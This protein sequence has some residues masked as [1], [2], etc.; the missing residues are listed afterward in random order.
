MNSMREIGVYSLR[1]QNLDL[2][3]EKGQLAILIQDPKGSD[4]YRHILAVRFE[5]KGEEISFSGVSHEEYSSEKIRQYLYRRGSSNGPDFTPTTRITEPVKTFNGKFLGWFSQDFDDPDLKFDDYDFL[6]LKN[7]KDCVFQNSDEICSQLVEKYAEIDKAENAILTLTI[8][9]GRKNYIGDYPCFRK[10]L[11]NQALNN[12]H[13]KYGKKSIAK[14]QVCSVCGQKSDEVY[15]FVSTYTFYTVDKPGMVAG[16]FDQTQT[17]KNYPV[18]QRCALTLEEG[19][20]YI[21]EYSSF[22]FYDFSYFVIPRPFK[23]ENNADIYEILEQF[24]GQNPEMKDRYSNLLDD[25]NDEIL[26]LLSGEEN[27]FNIS[28][29]IYEKSNS[30]FNILLNIEDVFPSKLKKL[31]EIKNEVDQIEIFRQL[32]VPVYENKKISH[33]KELAFSFG[34]VWHFF[35]RDK[36]QNTSTYFL[37][38]TNRIFT[39][40]Q[41]DYAFLLSGFVRKIRREFSNGW[42]TKESAMRSFQLLL[43][44]KRLEVL[45]I[46]E[47]DEMMEQKTVDEIFEGMNEKSQL[48]KSGVLFEEFFDFFNSDAKKAIFLEGV[49]AQ[50]LLD[51]QYN[52]R[53]A[54]PFR[55]KLLG[56][57]LDEKTVKRLLPEIQNKLEEYGKNYYRNLESEITR[58]YIQSGN[59]LCM[60][61]DEINYYFVLGMNLA[62]LFKSQ[63][64][65][66]KGEND[67]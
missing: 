44:L 42:P 45:S 4:T 40:K 59:R 65:D 18:C 58:Y 22:R 50:L 14:D 60:S 56:L 38:I 33:Y 21:E 25:A 16:G 15:G 10:I 47:E 55:T 41:I 28:I 29:L 49:L 51:I 13:N 67:E 36:E 24:K 37:E 61:K 63:K 26:E 8:D 23:K 64:S 57:R 31:F 52:E 7:L 48:E 27:S 11:K 17:W 9:D 19:K 46:P 34:N 12:Y 39:G 1:R 3:N 6:F 66:E 54:T 2:D 35:G 30:A 20:K 32:I 43:Y 62:Y 53:K 5:R